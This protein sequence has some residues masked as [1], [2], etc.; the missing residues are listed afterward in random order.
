MKL[1]KS[2][3]LAGLGILAFFALIGALLWVYGFTIDETMLDDTVLY[4]GARRKALQQ[5]GCI[6]V[7]TE[8]TNVTK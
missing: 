5:S 1:S 8:A 4:E 3:L 6:V 2:S 7:D